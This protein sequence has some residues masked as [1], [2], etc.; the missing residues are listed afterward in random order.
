MF[1]VNN[2]KARTTLLFWCLYCDFEQVNA[3][4]EG[5][6]FLLITFIATSL[7]DIQSNCTFESYNI[8]AIKLDLKGH[9]QIIPKLI[10][11]Q[12]LFS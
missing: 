7:D 1:K 11:D 6:F 5:F 10:S 4:C 2:K 3:S 12:K 8:T 9:L